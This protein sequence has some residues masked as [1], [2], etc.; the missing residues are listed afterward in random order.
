VI[1]F[2]I[3]PDFRGWNLN[4]QWGICRRWRGSPQN[5]SRT[6]RLHARLTA[7]LPLARLP[8]ARLPLARLPLARLESSPNSGWIENL[9]LKYASRDDR[10]LDYER[11]TYASEVCSER[12][13]QPRSGGSAVSPGCKPRVTMPSRWSSRVSG[14]RSEQIVTVERDARFL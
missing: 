7:R 14:G 11:K 8:L 9:A 2:T 4:V 13:I 6:R 3:P 5:A 12:R 1:V 10:F